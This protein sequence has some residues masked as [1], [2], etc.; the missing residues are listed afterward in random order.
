M[1]YAIHFFLFCYRGSLVVN[2]TIE[3]E[4]SEQTLVDVAVAFLNL[5][6]DGLTIFNKTVKVSGLTVEDEDGKAS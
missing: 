5:I 1:M 3:T 2:A 6:N 4:T